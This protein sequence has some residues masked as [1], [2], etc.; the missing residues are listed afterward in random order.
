MRELAR[1]APPNLWS[2]TARMRARFYSGER[3]DKAFSICSTNV[4]GVV[5]DSN[6]FGKCSTSGIHVDTTGLPVARYS[7]NF[8]GF[9][10]ITSRLR[11][12]GMMA[13]S[14][15]RAQSGSVW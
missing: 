2:A 9:T 5:R 15:H 12:K 8:S 13:T 3:W 1:F 6:V 11:R 4:S 7:L 14:K 10:L